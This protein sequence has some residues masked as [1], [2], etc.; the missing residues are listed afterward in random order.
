MN[1]R[2][3][4]YTFEFKKMVLML[5]GLT[6]VGLFLVVPIV[7]GVITNR[8]SPEVLEAQAA[9]LNAEANQ[10]DEMRGVI[11]EFGSMASTSG[12]FILYLGGG[13]LLIGAGLGLF[14]VF[15][16]LAATMGL[17]GIQRFF[18]RLA[19]EGFMY[20]RKRRTGE[21]SSLAVISPSASVNVRNT[22]NRPAPYQ[23][24][25]PNPNLIPQGKNPFD[26]GPE[27]ARQLDW[28][29]RKSPSPPNKN[30]GKFKPK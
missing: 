20:E 16:A 30:F 22:V 23:E 17:S 8:Q 6:L 9:L 27:K 14:F 25:K 3:N 13:V 19:G 28:P 2:G 26:P 12:P 24:I 4:N 29:E 11:Q 21:T 10:Y 15:V 18:N 1:K 7:D 5:V